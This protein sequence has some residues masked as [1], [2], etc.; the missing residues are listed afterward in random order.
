M[1]NTNLERISELNEA[2][3]WKTETE[4]TSLLGPLL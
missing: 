1:A 4:D 3:S 2:I